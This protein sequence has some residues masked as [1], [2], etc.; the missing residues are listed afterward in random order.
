MAPDETQRAGS[1]CGGSAL[2]HRRQSALG[3]LSSIALS[4]DWQLHS[5]TRLQ[6]PAEESY[7]SASDASASPD[8][9]ALPHTVAARLTDRSPRTVA[10][11]P[12]YHRVLTLGHRS[13]WPGFPGFFR[14]ATWQ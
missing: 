13:F 3:L 12:Q 8:R 9:A 1:S 4:S 7:H 6:A 14:C 11:A 10:S 2:V 5:I